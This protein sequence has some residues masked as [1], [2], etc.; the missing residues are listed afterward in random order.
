MNFVVLQYI[1]IV[2]WKLDVGCWIGV[3][4]EL[5]NVLMIPIDHRLGR[6]NWKEEVREVK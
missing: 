4:I 1:H 6:L 3:S 5:V 2:H